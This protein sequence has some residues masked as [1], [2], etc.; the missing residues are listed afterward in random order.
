[1]I[2]KDSLI[3]INSFLDEF[4]DSEDFDKEI[5]FLQVSPINPLVNPISVQ[6]G[7]L[8]IVQS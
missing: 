3:Y 1:M 8:V 5:Q 2:F 6:L 7:S 4:S